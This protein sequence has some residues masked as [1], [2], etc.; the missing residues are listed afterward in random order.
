M[1]DLYHM[2]F[3][4]KIYHCCLQIFFYKLSLNGSLHRC[5]LIWNSMVIY[6]KTANQWLQQLHVGIVFYLVVA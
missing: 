6:M 3:I 1:Y 5:S 4:S 2:G